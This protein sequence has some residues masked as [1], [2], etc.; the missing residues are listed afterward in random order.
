MGNRT[1]NAIP[2]QLKAS[3]QND[4]VIFV[5]AGVSRLAGG[6]SWDQF[7]D[8]YLNFLRQKNWLSFAEQ[9]QLSNVSTKEKLSIAQY[10]MERNQHILSASD[11]ERMLI[12]SGPPELASRLLKAIVAMEVPIVTT[13]YDNILEDAAVRHFQELDAS[14]EYRPHSVYKVSD[15]TE[16]LLK[17]YSSIVHLH[18]S[19]LEPKNAVISNV[20]YITHY[21]NS[22]ISNFMQSLF[23]SHTVLFLGYGMEE[24]EILAHM[25]NLKGDRFR[26]RKRYWFRD[27]FKFE[28]HIQ[29]HQISYFKDEYDIEIIPYY[30]DMRSFSELIFMT[31]ELYQTSPKSD[32]SRLLSS[33]DLFKDAFDD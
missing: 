27:Y 10:L 15:I 20:D 33:Y 13:N 7:A 12:N 5:G 4:L 19:I 26:A 29:K 23:S 1:F 3:V 28:R 17:S 16:D 6:C 24:A 9:E 2:E 31:E 14:K 30:K 25:F 8:N 32:K 22:N 21:A 11:F 18:G